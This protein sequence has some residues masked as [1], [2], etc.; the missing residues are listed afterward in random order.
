MNYKII[1][2]SLMVLNLGYVLAKHGDKKDENY[3]F[4]Y[5]SFNVS[6]WLG[7]LYGAGF[8]DDIR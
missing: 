6:V 3:N 4:W 7:L 2:L 8:F 5:S 1:L